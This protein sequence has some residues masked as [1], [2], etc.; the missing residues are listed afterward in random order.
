MSDEEKKLEEAA[1]IDVKAVEEAKVEEAKVEEQLEKDTSERL[2]KTFVKHEKLEVQP[3]P[4][5]ESDDPTP[6]EEPAEEPDDK[7]GPTAAEKKEEA[8]LEAETKVKVDEEK[9]DKEEEPVSDAGSKAK[10]EEADK[11]KSKEKEIP[12]LSDAYYRAAIHRGWSDEDIKDQYEANP[13]LTVRTLGNIYEALNRS[14]KEFAAHG[15]AAK[16]KTAEKSAPEPKEKTEQKSEFKGVDIDKLRKDYP[17]DPVVELVEAQQNQ[18]KA[19]HDRLQELEAARS[20]SE[21]IQPSGVQSRAV[22]QEH[23]AIQQQIETFFISDTLKGYEDFY[24]E[25]PKDVISWDGLTP[26]QKMNRWT[27]I[28]MMDQMV[29]GAATFG[30]EMKIDEAMNRAHLYVTE[31]I[32]EK[33]IREGIKAKVTERS[34]NLTLRPSGTAP[35]EETKPQSKQELESVTRQRLDKAFG[36]R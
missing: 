23:A 5:K 24:G 14:S 18:T 10:D 11:G 28:E 2:E 25:L 19:L 8:K 34:K 15:R 32:R 26:G 1:E 22:E 13:E 27:V 33:V 7:D 9:G 31:P 20:V 36:G 16:V 3:E 4:S 29:A 30:Q 35:S 17:D 21:T 6:E 12:P